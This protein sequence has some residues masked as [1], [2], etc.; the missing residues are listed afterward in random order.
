MKA[1]HFALLGTIAAWGASSTSLNGEANTN[2]RTF[3]VALDNDTVTGTDQN[4]TSGFEVTWSKWGRSSYTEGARYASNVKLDI[5]ISGRLASRGSETL[6]FRSIAVGQKIYTPSELSRYDYDS[7]DRPY[8]GWTYIRLS[9]EF[10]SVNDRKRIA[11]EGGTF[12]P[13]SFAGDFQRSIHDLIG[14][15]SPNGW[16]HQVEN[17]LAADLILER[18]KRIAS[19]RLAGDYRFV[20]SSTERITL[21]TANTNL[22]LGLVARLERNVATFK[23]RKIH[24]FSRAQLSAV[25]R[26]RTLSGP[27]PNSDRRVRKSTLVSEFEVGIEYR[28][29]KGNLLFSI[30]RVGRQFEGQTSPHYYGT[31]RYTFW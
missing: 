14:S 8:A 5:P 15:A 30:I 22:Q 11:V 21:G 28:T 27:H 29:Q 25:G 17:Q 26:D 19:R 18:E 1:I 3:S 10:A 23:P 6:S 2:G 16:A 4:Y 9:Y 20:A 24:Y 7:E 13:N 12:G 31:I